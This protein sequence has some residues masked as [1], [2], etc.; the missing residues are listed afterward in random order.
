MSRS[1][2]CFATICFFL[3]SSSCERKAPVPPTPTYSSGTVSA[4]VIGQQWSTS[5]TKANFARG[6][7]NRFNLNGAVYSNGVQIQSLSLLDISL[8][9][10]VQRII[11]FNSYSQYISLFDSVTCTTIFSNL[12]ND[13]LHN[14]YFAS[15]SISDNQ[16]VIEFYDP[17]TR[18]VKGSFNLHMYR[19][20][21]GAETPGFSDTMSIVNG[22]FDVVISN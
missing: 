13:A 9:D 18:N 22:K 4:V 16:I 17:Q 20:F 19:D 12:Y 7:Q 3:S 10:S 6:S 5:T 14:S 8:S 1:I 2:I 15:D 21:V 11:S